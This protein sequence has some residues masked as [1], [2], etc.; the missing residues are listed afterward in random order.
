VE[1]LC[2]HPYGCRVL[3]KAFECLTDSM[4]RRLLDEMHRSTPKL[5]E[6]Q[7]GSEYMC[8]AMSFADHVHVDYVVQSVV[9]CC[10]QKDKHKVIEEIKG[11]VVTRA[12]ILSY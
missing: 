10:Q 4:K 1:E 3:Q 2:L 9:I 11:K 7:F 8:R 12:S 5:I 6:D